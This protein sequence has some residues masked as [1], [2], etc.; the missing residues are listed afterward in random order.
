MEKLAE[1]SEYKFKTDKHR[2]QKQFY[3]PIKCKVSKFNFGR[4]KL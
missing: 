2:K 1:E 3:F 4:L